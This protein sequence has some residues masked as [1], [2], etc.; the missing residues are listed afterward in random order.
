M[1]NPAHTIM[2][3]KNVESNLDNAQE[4]FKRITKAQSQKD[5]TQA[6]EAVRGRLKVA[7]RN[8]DVLL[9]APEAILKE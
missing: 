1:H 8:L 3:L 4:S 6:L 2:A 9:P 5:V 7:L